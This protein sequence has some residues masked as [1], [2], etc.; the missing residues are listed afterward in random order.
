MATETSSECLDA[1]KW[2]NVKN[3]YPYKN[4]SWS[5]AF[6]QG[7][8]SK[9]EWGC[10]HKKTNSY[11]VIFDGV[12][13]EFLWS[14]NS[15]PT[16][17]LE[18]IARNIDF[19]GRQPLNKYVGQR[20]CKDVHKNVSTGIIRMYRTYYNGLW[21]AKKHLRV[22]EGNARLT[23]Q[24]LESARQTPSAVCRLA[25]VCTSLKAWLRGQTRQVVCLPKRWVAYTWQWRQNF[26]RKA[27]HA[28]IITWL[29]VL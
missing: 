3:H 23:C 2:A 18:T 16:E 1:R 11:H 14:R 26:P 20:M 10:K 29:S 27:N 13:V 4:L 15:L 8:K 9:L 19:R 7:Q 17:W 5:R 6:C 22:G 25:K 12:N 28:N 24:G 21:G